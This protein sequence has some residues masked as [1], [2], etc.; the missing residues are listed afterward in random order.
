MVI[1]RLIMLLVSLWLH[2]LYLC[3]LHT[4]H[5]AKW[6][7]CIHLLC[8]SKEC[9]IQLHHMFLNHMLDIF[10][11]CQQCHLCS[12]GRINRYWTIQIFRLPLV[13]TLGNTQCEIYSYFFR[14][15][16]RDHRY[17]RRMIHLHPKL[18]K[19]WWDQMLSLIMKCLLMAKLFI[20]TIWMLTSTK[21]RSLK[22]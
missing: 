11:Q 3:H 19:I 7:H 21:A 14:P 2:H 5:L 22:L 6:L 17:Q 1:Y 9:R 18:I 13:F 8:I 16:Q 20:E 10:T 4:S 15:S 12:S